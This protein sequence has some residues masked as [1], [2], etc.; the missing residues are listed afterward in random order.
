MMNKKLLKSV[1]GFLTLIIVLFYL[2]AFALDASF[3]R[4][5]SPQDSLLL[6]QA[7]KDNPDF[8][9]MDVRTPAETATGKI[10]NPIELDFLSPGFPN[11]LQKLDKQKAYFVYCR[12]GN[13]SGQA[14]A[15]MKQ[16]GFQRV[17]NMTGGIR[18]WE[19]LGYPITK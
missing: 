7:N 2:P 15:L 16:M 9:M 11:A 12:S 13:R 8:I 17:F 6:I 1:S 19:N 3:H 5:I 10:G 14:M 18:D 4:D